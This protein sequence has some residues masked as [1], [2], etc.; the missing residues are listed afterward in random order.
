MTDSSMRD[1][2]AADREHYLSGADEDEWEEVPAPSA[3]TAKRQPGAMISVRLSAPEA[4]EI[5]AA[6]DAAGEP[7]SAF[8]RKIVLDHVHGS[9]AAFGVF[10]STSGSLGRGMGHVEFEPGVPVSGALQSSTV[11]AA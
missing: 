3:R 11:L 1:R 6:A 7:V 5:R 8:V 10:A 4:D 9:S 2:I